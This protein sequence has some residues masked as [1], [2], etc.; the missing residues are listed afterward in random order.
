MVHHWEDFKNL[1]KIMNAWSPPQIEIDIFFKNAKSFVLKFLS[2]GKYLEG[3]D[4]SSITM[5]QVRQDTGLSV[6]V[7]QFYFVV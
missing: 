3:Y 1:Y 4:S 2:L 6:P 5:T 7:Y